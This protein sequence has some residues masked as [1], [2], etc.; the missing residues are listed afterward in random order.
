MIMN[1]D[2]N[3]YLGKKGT[4]M[5]KAASSDERCVKDEGGLGR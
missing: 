5:L 1:L 3:Q 4:K 2:G